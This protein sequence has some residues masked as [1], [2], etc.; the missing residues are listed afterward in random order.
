MKNGTRNPFSVEKGCRRFLPLCIMVLVL[1]S[2]GS[3]L[4]ARVICYK[5]NETAK[6]EFSL[7]G[8]E[9]RQNGGHAALDQFREDSARLEPGGC[10]DVPLTMDLFW[11]AP[12]RAA[13]KHGALGVGPR[14]VGFTYLPHFVLC[15]GPGIKHSPPG[16][17]VTG[18]FL[19]CLLQAVESDSILCRFRC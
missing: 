17:Q 3:W 2:A 1:Q 14:A 11:P 19:A 13:A 9:C 4:P 6:I 8:C 15:M 5:T 18:D 10:L 16:P 12:I 7:N